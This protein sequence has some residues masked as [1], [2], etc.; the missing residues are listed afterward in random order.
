MLSVVDF[1]NQFYWFY[2]IIHLH[3]VSNGEQLFS[4]LSILISYWVVCEQGSIQDLVVVRHYRAL[5]LV[6]GP[7]KVP[8][9]QHCDTFKVVCQLSPQCTIDG[10]IYVVDILYFVLLT[11]FC[12]WYIVEVASVP[13]YT[14]N[15]VVN[16]GSSFVCLLFNEHARLWLLQITSTVR[17]KWTPKWIAIILQKLVR[18]V[19]NFTHGKIETCQ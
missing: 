2:D 19:W 15:F 11:I 16:N 18:Y 12:Y 10:S 5:L 14:F 7:C 17:K 9:Q 4:G 6:L 13:K 1:C 3:N 8:Q